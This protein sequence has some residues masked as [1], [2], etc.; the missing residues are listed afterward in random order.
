MAGN[1]T[2]EQNKALVR[3]QFERVVNH[4]EFEVAD[5]TIAPHYIDHLAPSERARG[6]ESM[7]AFVRVQRAAYPDAHV[8]V[9]DIMAEGDRVAVRIAMRGTRARDGARHVFRGTVW[10]RVTDGMIVERWGAAFRREE[11]VG[12]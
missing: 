2:L 3:Q 5:A 11:L 8:T 6:P 12:E 9:E 7:K 4:Q 1:T 10:W